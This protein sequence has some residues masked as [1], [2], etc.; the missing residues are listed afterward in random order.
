MA[1]VG[2]A[3]KGKKMEREREEES[4]G[5]KSQR[6]RKDKKRAFCFISPIQNRVA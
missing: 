3:E 6:K 4:G 5:K 2:G 1:N